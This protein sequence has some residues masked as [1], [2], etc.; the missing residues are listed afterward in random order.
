MRRLTRDG[1]AE[2]VSRDQ[3]LRRERGQGN[4]YFPC[5]ADHEQDW[6]PCS[7]DPYS[8][9]ICD[10]TTVSLQSST[11]REGFC[12]ST[13]VVC[14]AIVPAVLG[15]TY[16]DFFLFHFFSSQGENCVR[17]KRPSFTYE[18]TPQPFD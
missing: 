1:T 12:S 17:K 15:R 16:V 3:L 7:V 5:S 8:C 4:I 13:V 6:P 11:V 10:H 2:F 14:C 9:H 18:A